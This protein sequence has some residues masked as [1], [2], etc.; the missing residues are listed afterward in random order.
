M[1]IIKVYGY[2]IEFDDPRCQICGMDG[3]SINHVLFIYSLAR[4]VWALSG[5]PFLEGG[6]DLHAIYHNL[7]HV[8]MMSRNARLSPISRRSLPWI[9]WPLWKNHNNLIFG[10]MVFMAFDMMRKIKEDFDQWF[11]TQELDQLEEERNLEQV[12]I[13]LHNWRPTHMPW[14]KC[15][16]A[17]S[18]IKDKENNGAEWV[19]RNWE[20][21]VLLHSRRF[22]GLIKSKYI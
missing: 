2:D 8:G 13:K 4:Q 11:Q 16:I 17:S 9:L 18:W 7:H 5:F 1:M 21:K 15:N 19:L 10:G 22:S 6:F 3:E 14:L 12:K 20:G